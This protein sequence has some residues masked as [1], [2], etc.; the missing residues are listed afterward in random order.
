MGFDVTDVLGSFEGCD[1]RSVVEVSP[2]TREFLLLQH[3][4]L[5]SHE[6]TFPHGI[7][8]P[9]V[10][11]FIV[12]NDVCLELLLLLLKQEGEHVHPVAFFPTVEGMCLFIPIGTCIAPVFAYG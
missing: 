11:S 4:Y 2:I 9:L 8:V 12:C 3:V 1:V 5:D 6:A 10:G 7:F